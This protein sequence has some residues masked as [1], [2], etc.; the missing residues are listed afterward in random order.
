MSSSICDLQLKAKPSNLV[1]K[2]QP[3]YFCSGLS[4]SMM[5]PLYFIGNIPPHVVLY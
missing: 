1:C 2:V 4:L 3:A 5:D